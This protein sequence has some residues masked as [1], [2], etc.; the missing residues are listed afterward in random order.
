MAADNTLTSLNTQFK[1]IQAKATSLLPENAVLLK[2]IPELTEAQ[3]EGRLYLVPCQLSHENGV[4]YG[5]G[6]VF[7]LNSSAAAI[8]DEI[9]VDA[10]PI[11]LVTQLSES[12]VNRM[13]NSEKSFISES[14][15]RMRVMY[16]SLA[17]YL[18][19][20]MLYGKSATGLGTLATAVQTGSTTTCVATITAAQWSAGIWG[21]HIGGV[22]P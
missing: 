17:R 7:A 3:K 5:D 12:V 1:Y 11:I 13:L 10:Q 21:S 8:Y 15:L 19:I 18:E 9:E 6:T 22:A 20:S 16:D 14:T 2:I 4:T